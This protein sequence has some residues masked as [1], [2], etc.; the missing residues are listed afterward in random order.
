VQPTR[1]QEHAIRLQGDWCEP[2]EPRGDRH[3]GQHDHRR[4]GDA[5][6]LRSP[7]SSASCA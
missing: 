3:H 1:E 4:R 5:P 6:A 7:S 2:D